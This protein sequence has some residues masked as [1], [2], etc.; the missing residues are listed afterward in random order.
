[1]LEKQVYF[2]LEIHGKDINETIDKM[3]GDS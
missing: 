2:F 1:M 3:I